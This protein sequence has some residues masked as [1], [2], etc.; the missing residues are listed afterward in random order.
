MIF[1]HFS[2]KTCAIIGV[3]KG[4]VNFVNQTKSIVFTLE[5]CGHLN[6]LRAANSDSSVGMMRLKKQNQSLQDYE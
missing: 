1:Y 2:F 5:I 3:S 6:G 4:K